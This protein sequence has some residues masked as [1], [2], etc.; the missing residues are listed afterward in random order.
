MSLPLVYHPDH[1]APLP[2][3]H[4]FPMAKFGRLYEVL[5]RDGDAAPGQFH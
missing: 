5:V 1:V 3:G 2:P 4:R